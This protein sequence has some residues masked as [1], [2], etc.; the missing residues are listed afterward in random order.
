M[1]ATLESLLR[2]LRQY[3]DASGCRLNMDKCGV[4]FQGPHAPPPGTVLY[5]VSVRSKVK[6]LGT[7]LG[8]ATVLNQY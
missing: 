3:G 4:V 8:H 5:G 2:L 1:R 7:W 6:Y